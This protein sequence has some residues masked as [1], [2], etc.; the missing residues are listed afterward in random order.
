MKITFERNHPPILSPILIILSAILF[1]APFSGS[2]AP[3]DQYQ[4]INFNKN[5]YLG[6]NKNW[7][8]NFDSEGFTYFGNTIGLIEFDGVSWHI[9]PSPNGF[10][11]RTIAIDSNNR[12]Y[13]G[14]YREIGF[15]ERNNLGT[16][17]YTSLTEQV[18]HYFAKNEEFWNIFIIDDKIYFQSFSGI[19]IYS[20]GQFEFIRINGFISR[21]DVL[22]QEPVIAIQG[23]GL[24]RINNNSYSPLLESS[25]FRD[26]KINFFSEYQTNNQYLIGTESHGMFLY[27]GATQQLKEWFSEQKDFLI[28]NNINK[29]IK[30]PDGSFAIGTILNG[31]IILS[32]NGTVQ[33]HLT[34]QS[35][36]QSNTVH[37]LT[38]D[39]TG[40]IWVASDKGL[41]FISFADSTSYNL[42]TKH[43]PG[44]MYSAGIHNG[45]FYV[46]TNQ[47]LFYRKWDQSNTPFTLVQGTQRQVW[48]C[49]V[50]DETLFVG[51]NSGTFIVDGG[52]AQKISDIAGGYSITSIPGHPDF[53]LQCTFSD[54][55]VYQKIN[56]KWQ[57]AHTVK[58]FSDLI[59]FV[60]FDHRNN[61]WAGHLYHGLYKLNLNESL[62]SVVQIKHYGKDSN[63]WRKGSSLRVFN[64]EN[65]IIFSNN[66]SLYT[67]DDLTDQIVPYEFLN[68]HLGDYA[69]SFLIVPAP[70][71]RYWFMNEHGIAQFQIKQDRIQKIKEFPL[72]LFRNNLIP[73]EENI[74][75][76]DRHKA[77]LCLENGYAILDTE[78]KDSGDQITRETL[79]IRA[80][81]TQSQTGE[82]KKLSPYQGKLS[83]PFAQNNLTLRYSFPLFSAEPVQYQ[84]KIEGLT[85]R[86]S[87]PLESPVFTINRIPAGEYVIKVRATNQ[88]EKTSATHELQLEVAP[89]W[90][91]STPAFFIYALVFSG[92]FY[93]GKHI[94]VKRVKLYEKHKREEK[95]RE[96][97]R[98][99]NEKLQSELSF[100]SRQLANSTLE[101]IKKN[102]FLMALKD[103]LK[104]QKEQLGTRYPDKYYNELI[105]K[106]D[107]HISGGDD[108]KIFEHNFNQAHETFL[109]SIKEAYPQLTPSDLR[110]CAFLRI[111]LTSKEIAP[112]LGIS[113]RGVENHRYRLRKKLELSPD[114]DLTE[115]ILSFRDGKKE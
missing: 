38:C 59:R 16:L 25:F 24:Y 3:I 80:I 111:N 79:K 26:K 78:S 110:L 77:I 83:I 87:A 62:D 107:D 61:L 43:S 11:I 34:I 75:T 88:W 21:S 33:H 103:K 99:R 51:H 27:D 70:D 50:I 102:E 112:L 85:P 42:F 98:L 89:P 35:G 14:G 72:S 56:G 18:E 68:N 115:F 44:A 10:A 91:Q 108:W 95:E 65:R 41:D 82:P 69:S 31:V 22:N 46:G 36:L 100:K 4:V 76:V 63:I 104:K 92:L 106:I 64:I 113:V 37:S 19:Y 97:I 60:E 81:I 73:R 58:G 54:L 86:W 39:T 2:A 74:V 29:G 114:T 94:T 32:E 48:D 30:R 8:I 47:G 20:D 23:R 49:K 105:R 55:V 101:M 6:A 71:N 84:Y 7:C 90:Y 57:F 17:N 15:W 45:L 12:I 52:K 40:N 66:D 67:Y 53:L 1:G 96:L 28:R 9:Y 5:H 109:Q 93:L 13:T